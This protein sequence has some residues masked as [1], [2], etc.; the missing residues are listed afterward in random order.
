MTL[1]QRKPSPW[2]Y[3]PNARGVPRSY[4]VHWRFH[5]HELNSVENDPDQIPRIFFSISL[6]PRS[7]LP[8][9]QRGNA[10]A[11]CA[12][13]NMVRNCRSRGCS[14]IARVNQSDLTATC[15]YNDAIDLAYTDAYANTSVW[16]DVDVDFAVE[17]ACHDCV[18]AVRVL[19]HSWVSR[20]GL[21]YYFAHV[22]VAANGVTLPPETAPVT[23][24]EHPRFTPRRMPVRPSATPD[25]PTACPHH[26]PDTMAL[27]SDASTWP[28]G[29]AAYARAVRT[30]PH[31]AAADPVA[32][33]LC[34]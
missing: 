9:N 3:Y 10:S 17:Y 27:W 30:T 12:D 33:C 16:H 20:W 13:A 29:M 34:T 7:A 14:T 21:T 15:A 23:G 24:D 32:T 11:V 18:L 31:T 2:T 5:Q 26:A 19:P 4:H 28:N 1:F 22:T 6:V 8:S 25:L